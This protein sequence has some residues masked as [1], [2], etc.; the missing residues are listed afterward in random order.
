MEAYIWNTIIP[1]AFPEVQDPNF[2]DL[3][4]YYQDLVLDKMD[5]W[6]KAFTHESF[7]PNNNYQ[8]LEFLGD[9]V[10]RLMVAEYLIQSCSN[11]AEGELT[12]LEVYYTR[13]T[14]QAEFGRLLGLSSHIRSIFP[15]VDKTVT[16]VFEAVVGAL[17]IISNTVFGTGFGCVSCFNY[18]Q[19]CI[20]SLGK[21]PD[22]ILSLGEAPK[23]D[24]IKLLRGMNWIKD[25][26]MAQLSTTYPVDSN[27]FFGIAWPP[28]SAS[29][30]A[31]NNIPSGLFLGSATGTNSKEA[32]TKAYEQVLVTLR[33]YGVTPE[34]VEALKLERIP[35]MNEAIQ[36]VRKEGYD[37]IKIDQT[38]AGDALY[39]RLYAYRPGA[40][41]NLLLV[42]S[43]I[44]DRVQAQQAILAWYL[45][46][47]E[48]PN[49]IISV[50][51]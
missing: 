5:I 8:R 20:D 51:S 17:Y 3:E 37:T 15:V 43:Y 24:A 19:W 2:T 38:R 41:K 35:G 44:P 22:E 47:G 25:V 42:R 32:E 21:T 33:K 18:N 48:N 39:F 26:T 36:K 27:V 11:C 1:I 10:Q 30:I 34:S 9:R 7:D 4:G 28:A 50:Y 45:K 49:Q 46:N 12:I 31:Q 14:T 40:A 6:L 29:F 13:G 16:D 23:T